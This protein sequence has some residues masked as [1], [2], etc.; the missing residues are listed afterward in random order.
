MYKKGDLCVINSKTSH[1][2][3][4]VVEVIGYTKGKCKNILQVQIRSRT[5]YITE[6][7]LKLATRYD[8]IRNLSDKQLKRMLRK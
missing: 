1:N 5:F 7:S 3:G 2:N 8:I 6:N 4:K